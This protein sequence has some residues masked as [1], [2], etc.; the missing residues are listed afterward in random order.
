MDN[1]AAMR[2]QASKKPCLDTFI[3]DLDGTLLDTLPD[4][5]ELTNATLREC[6]WPERTPQEVLSFVGN[7]VKA[8]MYQAVPEGANSEDVESA[9]RRWKALYPAYGYRLT[10]AYDG[11]PETIAELKR[12]GAKLAVLSNKFD[13]AVHEVVDAYLP[14]LFA[15]AHGE[16]ADIPR[17]PNPA[18][19]LRT[20]RELGSSPSRTA[21]VGDSTGD[22][23]VSR[24]AG[25]FSIAVAWGYHTEGRLLE[26]A[27]DAIVQV[28][29]RI[30]RTFP[31][32]S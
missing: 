26:A 24:N 14:D 25:V 8:L 22:V 11:I 12:R 31:T 21:Y 7:G 29:S 16:C 20:I 17:K 28:P 23:T 10:K 6:G 19:L 4:L 27:P 5:V 13:G 18:G 1:N 3:F 15:I 2:E 32:A 30:L 9:L